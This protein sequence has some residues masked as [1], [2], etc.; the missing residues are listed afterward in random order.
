MNSFATFNQYFGPL[1][2]QYCVYFY[3][4][5]IMFAISFVMSFLSILYF[6][7]MHSKKVNMMFI[8]NAI[9]ILLNTF[10]AYF[11]NRLLNTMCIRSV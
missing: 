3:A 9:F 4:L 5:S 6:M 1:P 7:I 10:L 8:V 11:V 2:K